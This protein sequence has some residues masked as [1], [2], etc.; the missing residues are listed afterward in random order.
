VG[1]AVM[2]FIIWGVSQFITSLLPFLAVATLLGGVAYILTNLLLGGQEI[3][4]LV[5]LVRSR[6]V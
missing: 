5:R 6:A 3:P 4:R 1:T 2:S